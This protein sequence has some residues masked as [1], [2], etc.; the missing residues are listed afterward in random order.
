MSAPTL[1][2]CRALVRH[3]HRDRFDAWCRSTGAHSLGAALGLDARDR[4][5]ILEPQPT[6]WDCFAGGRKTTTIAECITRKLTLAVAAY[7]GTDVAR[8]QPLVMLPVLASSTVLDAAH[9]TPDLHVF[10]MDGIARVLPPRR[11]RLNVPIRVGPD[12]DRWVWGTT[13]PAPPVDADPG[14]AYCQGRPAWDASDLGVTH[15]CLT[16]DAALHMLVAASRRHADASARTAAI[17][18]ALATGNW[19]VGLGWTGVT[20]L[21]RLNTAL[22]HV[23]QL[24]TFSSPQQDAGPAMRQLGD[25]GVGVVDI[26]ATSEGQNVGL[27]AAL[28]VQ[29]LRHGASVGGDPVAAAAAVVSVA[30]GPGDVPAALVNGQVVLA[31]R[32]DVGSRPG[33]VAAVLELCGPGAHARW[34]GGALWIF[35]VP[36]LLLDGAGRWLGSVDPVDPRPPLSIA[37]VTGCVSAAGP[38]VGFNQASRAT[39]SYNMMQRAAGA[40]VTPGATLRPRL[41]DFYILEYGQSPVVTTCATGSG[42]DDLA[43][44]S[45]VSCSVVVLDTLASGGNPED[46]VIVSQRFADLGGLSLRRETTLEATEDGAKGKLLGR[47][48]DA[49]P[50]SASLVDDDGLIC[51]G[52][53]VRPGDVVASFVNGSTV[54]VPPRWET[55]GQV[56]SVAITQAD[57]GDRNRTAVI[58]LASCGIGLLDGDK[59]V[60]RACSQKG[61]IR[62]VAAEDMPWSPVPELDGGFDLVFSASALP[63]RMTPGVCVRRV[64]L[65]VRTR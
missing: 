6:A 28:T 7:A 47:A 39:F 1:A 57:H 58:R 32:G 26:F 29:R 62:L 48:P 44:S 52:T 34:H 10:I 35:T 30:G 41:K 27:T 60:P 31:A 22:A 61:T 64:S 33:E 51:A 11:V 59:L 37:D 24:T 43:S 2:D 40:G 13:K 5:P 25:G 55:V 38:Y 19:P 12:N 18:S 15:R 14:V 54:K 46:A 16:V 42:A 49:A 56:E 17:R 53:V 8:A 36:G 3:W 50:F 20:H 65:F 21:A 23:A 4:P 45:G 63:S 9:R